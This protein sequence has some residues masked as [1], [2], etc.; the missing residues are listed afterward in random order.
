MSKQNV[1][2]ARRSILG[3]NERGVD[4]LVEHRDSATRFA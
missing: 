2:F 4:A 1:E 3:W